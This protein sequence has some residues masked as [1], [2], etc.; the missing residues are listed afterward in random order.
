MQQGSRGEICF[1]PANHWVVAFRQT[2][3]ILTAVVDR[4]EPE[5][6]WLHWQGQQRACHPRPALASGTPVYI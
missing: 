1:Q 3:N 2:A 5:T 6:L 4:V